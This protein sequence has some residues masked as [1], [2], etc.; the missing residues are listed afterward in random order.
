M[1]I[2]F[3]LIALILFACNTKKKNNDTAAKIDAFLSGQAKH[4][5]FNGNVLIAEN[6]KV[7]LQKSYGYADFDSKRLLNDS[8]V[9]ELASVSKQ[10]TATGILLLKDKGKLK[11]TDSLRQY[12][13]EL[14]YAGITISHMLSH[15]SGLPD[16]EEAM[17]QKWNRSKIA[18]NNDMIAFLAK[19]KPAVLFTP[20]SSWMYSNTAYAILASIIEKVSGQT[21]NQYMA[22]NI[23]QPLGMRH[24]RIYNT[25]RSLKDTIAN[26]AYGFVYNDS[27]KKYFLPDSVAELKFV[28]YLDGIVGDGVVNSTTADLL[29][30]DR[31]VK[32][33]LLLKQETQ[34]EMLKGQA[35]I[36][37]VKNTQ[38]G[39]GVFLEKNDFGNIISHSGGWPGY[40]T[41]L[42]RNIEK[43]QTYIILSNNNANSPVICKTLQHIMTGNPVVMPA[44]HTAIKT[45]SLALQKFTGKYKT[46]D[47]EIRLERKGAKLFRTSSN[48]QSIELTPASATSFFYSDGSDRQIEFELTA[49]NKVNKAWLIAYGIKTPLTK[50]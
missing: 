25:R 5:R 9:F 47:N 31:A 35:I 19:E 16:Y 48:G 42:A 30:W 1:K 49:D 45:D 7:V 6:G 13:P 40:V 26:Y 32:N 24:T 12:F 4:Y 44:Q 29:K 37:T 41:F 39:F 17:N 2:V 23:F 50:N 14:P 33:H 22:E 36:D 11:L 28:I 46:I 8:S 15:T 43:D 27:L 38:Y 3:P 20:G 18:F 21:F 10:F 34:T